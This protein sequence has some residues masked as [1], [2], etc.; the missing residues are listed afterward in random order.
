MRA[1]NGKGKNIQKESLGA[2]IPNKFD[3]VKFLSELLPVDW[4]ICP[5]KYLVAVLI[6]SI[7][8][9]LLVLGFIMA[10]FALHLRSL[11]ETQYADLSMNIC[12]GVCVCVCVCVCG[13]CACVGAYIDTR[14]YTHYWAL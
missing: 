9:N 7:C 1:T 5:I 10:E 6:L 14:F 12:F 2:F 3:I 8:F 11:T 13:M 4:C